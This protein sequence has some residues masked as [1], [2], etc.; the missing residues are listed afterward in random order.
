MTDLKQCN[1]VLVQLK[2][3]TRYNVEFVEQGDRGKMSKGAG[4]ID[5]P[6]TASVAGLTH[7]MHFSNY[8]AHEGGI[9]YTR[10]W[11]IF[12]SDT[13]IQPKIDVAR[14]LELVT[15]HLRLHFSL[16]LTVSFPKST[17]D[18][19]QNFESTPDTQTALHGP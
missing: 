8:R 14:H 4:S 1:S 7:T 12:A 5:P 6:N 17:P 10:H 16:T 9:S 2:Y 3:P 18:I 19:T 13:D 11:A 15:R